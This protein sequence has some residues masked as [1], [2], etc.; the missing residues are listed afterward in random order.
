MQL[1]TTLDEGVLHDA[2]PVVASLTPFEVIVLTIVLTPVLVHPCHW[3]LPLPLPLPFP[4][5]LGL[6]VQTGAGVD[7]EVE[8]HVVTALLE[9][10]YGKAVNQFS[11]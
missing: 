3:P 1:V 4:F 10:T 6:V 7:N 9:G 2:E 8:H 5:P 11:V